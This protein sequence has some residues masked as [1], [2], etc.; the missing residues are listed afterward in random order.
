MLHRS[1]T[2]T[3]LG[4]NLPLHHL[5]SVFNSPTIVMESKYIPD[6]NFD[7]LDIGLN[8]NSDIERRQQNLPKQAFS[9]QSNENAKLE[10]RVLGTYELFEPILLYLQGGDLRKARLVA[11]SWNDIILRSEALD[12]KRK[13]LEEQYPFS[14]DLKLCL[15]G[16]HGVGKRQLMRRVCTDNTNSTSIWPVADKEAVVPRRDVWPPPQLTLGG[17]LKGD[18]N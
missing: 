15:L 1:G 18:K 2:A 4:F 10:E 6:F 14:K 11:K 8:L 7:S 5:Q 12:A 16:D 17:L 13:W 9:K 3:S